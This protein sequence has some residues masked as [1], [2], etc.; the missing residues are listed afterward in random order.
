MHGTRITIHRSLLHVC[1]ILLTVFCVAFVLTQTVE[2][3]IK[4]DLSSYLAPAV[5]YIEGYGAPY[6]DFFDIKPPVAIFFLVPWTGV[7]GFS[8]ISMVV[9][10]A[11]TLFLLFYLFFRLLSICKSDLFVYFIF[12]Y[13]L[14]YA[15]SY[16]LFGLML[17]TETVGL[18]FV[19]FSLL[20]AFSQQSG[21][22]SW[23]LAGMLLQFAGQVK[24][25]YAFTPIIFAAF[26]WL[27]NR[28]YLREALTAFL[29]WCVGGLV[30][31]F[32]LFSSDSH[33]AYLD[34]LAF[35][36]DAFR[37]QDLVT[38][39]L[40]MIKG[41]AAFS[42]SRLKFYL[43]FVPS[44]I[45]LIVFVW[46]IHAQR[47]PFGLRAGSRAHIASVFALL[48]LAVI[49]GFA[50]QGKPP[51]GHYAVSIFF[52]YMLFICAWFAALREM[53]PAIA[54]PKKM[55]LGT[56]T[57][58]MVLLVWFCAVLTPGLKLPA[59]TSQQIVSHIRG[60]GFSIPELEGEEALSRYRFVSSNLQEGDCLQ[61][62]Y[63]WAAGTAYLYTGTKPCSRHFLANLITNE[64]TVNE[65][66]Q[67][68]QQSSPTVV[69]YN[70]AGADLD[71]ELF[72]KSIFP[73][74]EIV[75]N[76][77]LPTEFA[78]IFVASVQLD[79]LENCIKVVLRLKGIATEP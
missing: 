53:L 44:L 63:G 11:I 75:S 5:A 8:L 41:L 57:I 33:V 79:G 78:T 48:L 66:V 30:V 68:L 55:G 14:V 16:R 64:T 12:L 6:V 21:M 18:V 65:Y 9:L 52:P 61:Q 28:F 60:G 71:V 56:G 37:V 43:F 70:P 4:H 42:G 36:A 10:D 32:L 19:F 59:Q 24:E 34:V 51:S 58:S 72:E 74:G 22:K 47:K 17:L 29:G 45:L 39:V 38:M 23:F 50:W 3:T 67:D 2:A 46:W 49:V 73:W 1:A 35:K 20:L 40:R 69:I 7:F 27:D 15:L 54:K 25:V 76:C 31:F 13:A 62:A 26:V 77:Y